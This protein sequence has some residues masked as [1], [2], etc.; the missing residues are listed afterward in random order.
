MAVVTQA[1]LIG[2]VIRATFRQWLDVVALCCQA[3]ATMTAALCTERV[4]LEKVGTHS[5]QP[6]ASDA[7]GCL[8]WLEPWSPWML[9]AAACAIT[10]QDAAARMAAWLGCA[11]GHRGR[12]SSE[13]LEGR[14]HQYVVLNCPAIGSPLGDVSGF[15]RTSWAWCKSQPGTEAPGVDTQPLPV[16]AWLYWLHRQDLNLRPLGYEPNELPAA[17][18]CGKEK[19]LQVVAC[20]GLVG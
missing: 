13:W 15:L 12:V 19:P 10:H 11:D 14:G 20:R 8:H 6:P 7:L 2:F 5:L 17:P 1:L 4:T 3:H 16:S 9:G 18:R